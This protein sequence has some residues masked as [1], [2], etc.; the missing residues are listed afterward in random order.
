MP[1]DLKDYPYIDFTDGD[2][3]PPEEIA[4]GRPVVDQLADPANTNF[5]MA[6]ADG[7]GAL[8]E[9]ANIRSLLAQMAGLG[10]NVTVLM[11]HEDN[12]AFP[13]MLLL[14]DAG[15]NADELLEGVRAEI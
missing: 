4:R 1:H 2:L 11:M 6:A 14:P 13:Q 5:Y 10:V 7:S 12:P 8:T 9:G 15:S 3:A